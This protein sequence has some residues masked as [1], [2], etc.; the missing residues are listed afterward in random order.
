M[1]H[2]LEVELPDDERAATDEVALLET[3]RALWVAD[4][5][6]A[7]LTQDDD[8]ENAPE[9][10][11]A[12]APVE[13]AAPPVVT[14]PVVTPLQPPRFRRIAAPRSSHG[15]AGLKVNRELPSAMNAPSL[16]YSMPCPREVSAEQGL[17]CAPLAH[18]PPELSLKATGQEAKQA[19]QTRSGDGATRKR[20]ADERAMGEARCIKHSQKI[21]TA[22]WAEERYWKG[23][24][25]VH[26]LAAD[27]EAMRGVT[28]RGVTRPPITRDQATLAEALL[29]KAAKQAVLV[30]A[31]N[32]NM[33]TA[34]A[35]FW[36][37]VCALEA[38]ARMNEGGYVVP[39]EHAAYIRSWPGLEAT[40][41][42][43]KRC[44]E[45]VR[46]D[47]HGLGTT[48]RFRRDYA[49]TDVV[50]R[51][52]TGSHNFGNAEE[53]RK[54]IACL[55][56]LLRG[57]GDQGLH[58]DIKIL[59]PPTIVE[60]DT[61]SHSLYAHHKAAAAKRWADRQAAKRAEK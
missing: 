59:K 29:D 49:G 25:V 22:D 4:L 42:E 8:L 15:C 45:K 54:K 30:S 27:G 41:E 19:K 7:L 48:R 32:R 50:V 10:A 28:K 56:M 9:E 47:R 55:D 2:Y 13:R 16:I 23:R 18:M 61:P 36:A 38:F 60:H 26:M 24:V 5:A 12:A 37:V 21:I 20:R 52:S 43:I 51:R 33:P 17:V 58:F 14:P 39:S 35:A 1:L 40:Y 57:A 11:V 34:S 31:S 46:E 44:D 53:K 3:E 6:A